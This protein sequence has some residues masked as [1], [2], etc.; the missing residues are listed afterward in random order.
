MHSDPIENSGHI[1]NVCRPTCASQLNE[2]LTGSVGE[3]DQRC[4][5]IMILRV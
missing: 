4:N 5:Y 3:T 1:N 2:F